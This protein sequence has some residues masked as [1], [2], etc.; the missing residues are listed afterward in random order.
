MLLAL[1]P[2]IVSNPMTNSDFNSIVN[3]VMAMTGRHDFCLD[4]LVMLFMRQPAPEIA[5]QQMRIES[6][7]AQMGR[8]QPKIAA[9]PSRQITEL[10]MDGL[11][12]IRNW[13]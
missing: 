2:M 6:T 4:K 11:D 9:F 7:W 12:N 1:V 3:C 10:I 8:G 13:R 5:H